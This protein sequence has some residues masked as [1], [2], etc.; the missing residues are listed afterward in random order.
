MHI[1]K[2]RGDRRRQDTTAVEVAPAAEDATSVEDAAVRL[3]EDRQ[4]AAAVK[5][6]TRAMSVRTP[7]PLQTPLMLYC[8]VNGKI[9]CD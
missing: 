7:P 1:E 2:Y 8:S 9:E 4:D 3:R 6:A 5:E